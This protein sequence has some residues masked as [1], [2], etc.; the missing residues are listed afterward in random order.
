MYTINYVDGAKKIKIPANL[1]YG[2][3]W[4]FH[5]ERNRVKETSGIKD[6]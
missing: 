5:Y 4:H 2:C 1:Y 6:H 3:F